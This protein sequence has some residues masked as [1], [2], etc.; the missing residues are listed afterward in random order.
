MPF[1]KGKSGNPKGM[2]PGTKHQA[3]DEIKALSRAIFSKDYWERIRREA[4]AGTLHPKIETTLLAYA[5]GAPQ[6]KDTA[7]GGVTVNLG[8]IALPEPTERQQLTIVDSIET[9]AIT[10]ETEH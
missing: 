1:I 2:K 9:H 8:F 5:Y 4:L 6:G 10:G 7:P 3:T